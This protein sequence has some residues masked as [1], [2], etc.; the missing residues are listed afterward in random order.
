MAD[1][2]V[3]AAAVLVAVGNRDLLIER[4]QVLPGVSAA[5]GKRLAEKGMVEAFEPEPEVEIVE[6]EPAKLKATKRATDAK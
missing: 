3:T 5:V 6:P 4:G 2:R 1:Y